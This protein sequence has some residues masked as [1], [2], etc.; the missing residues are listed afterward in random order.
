MSQRY[1]KASPNIS[2]QETLIIN[3]EMGAIKWGHAEPPAA[4]GILLSPE[5]MLSCGSRKSSD[6]LSTQGH[7][8]GEFCQ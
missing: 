3:E 8:F 1:K 5:I 6:L 4:L 7:C 2:R